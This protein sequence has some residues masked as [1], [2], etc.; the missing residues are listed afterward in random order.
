MRSTL[1]SAGLVSIVLLTPARADERAQAREHFNKGS[2]YFSLGKFDEAIKEYEAA[3]DLK[4]DPAFLYNI[5]QAYRLAGN[6][7][8]ALFFY[9]SY[10][11]RAPEA[12]NLKDVQSKIAE[13]QK[14]IDQQQKTQSLPPDDQLPPDRRPDVPPPANPPPPTR[15][16]SPRVAAGPADISR[17]RT[18]LYTGIA[19][20]AVGGAGLLTGA[21]L[22]GLSAAYKSDIENASRGGGAYDPDKDA[23]RPVLL[24]VGVA[25]GAVGA[26][27]L[28]L[29]KREQAAAK[30]SWAPSMMLGPSGLSASVGGSF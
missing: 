29:G 23:A 4:D 18:K 14:L 17:G 24:G 2:K 30:T 16:E 19:L 9:R 21:T 5:A 28:A 10:L 25:A 20:V 15:L 8:K 13:L 22:T 26:V 11:S 12:P 7:P 6:A 1:I 27:L 3:Y